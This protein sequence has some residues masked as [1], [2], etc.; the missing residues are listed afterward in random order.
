MLDN[1]DGKTQSLC[2]VALI[3]YTKFSLVMQHLACFVVRLFTIVNNKKHYWSKSWGAGPPCPLGS[4][5]PVVYNQQW[6]KFITVLCMLLLYHWNIS[7][8][9]SESEAENDE[10][11]KVAAFHPRLKN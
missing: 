2:C 1:P 4:Y 9:W 8:V 3:I 7:T 10:C 11:E 5:G 6:S